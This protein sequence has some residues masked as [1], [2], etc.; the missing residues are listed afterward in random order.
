MGKGPD[1][2]C[3]GR[4]GRKN[5]QEEGGNRP[6]DFPL[7]GYRRT[8][9]HRELALAPAK[10]AHAITDSPSDRS[11]VPWIAFRHARPSALHFQRRG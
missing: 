8:R 1:S 3:N 4:H 10:L 6:P 7:D 2:G 9:A 11:P 5:A